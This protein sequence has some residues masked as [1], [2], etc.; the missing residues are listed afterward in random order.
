M[1]NAAVTF[2]EALKEQNFY[3]GIMSIWSVLAEP[4]ED[5]SPFKDLWRFE[6]AYAD[7]VK[8]RSAKKEQREAMKQNRV[9]EEIPF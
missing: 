9:T 4:A 1:G 5:S 3:K 7:K 8:A 6:K 2:K